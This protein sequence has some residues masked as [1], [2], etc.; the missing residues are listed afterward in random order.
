MSLPQPRIRPRS[1][2]SFRL[3]PVK[4]ISLCCGMLFITLPFGYAF[5][6]EFPIS[7][8]PLFFTA[9]LLGWLPLAILVRG[10][11]NN[12]PLRDADAWLFMYSLAG[13]P[14]VLASS[15]PQVGGIY[16]IVQLF[17]NSIL[18][19]SLPKYYGFLGARPHRIVVNSLSL[20]LLIA[21]LVSLRIALLKGIGF[22]SSSRLDG[23]DSAWVHANTIGNFA[24]L[25]IASAVLASWQPKWFRW[26]A[27][28]L[29]AHIALLSQSRGSIVS[30]AVVLLVALYLTRDRLRVWHLLPLS[31]VGLAIVT[32]FAANFEVSAAPIDAMLQR[33]ES[34]KTDITVG[35]LEE[36]ATLLQRVKE[37]PAFG[38]GFR[39]DG[40]AGGSGPMNVLS[41]TGIIG[42]GVYIFFLYS[43]LRGSI[44]AL[45]RPETRE[46][47]LCMLALVSYVTI[48]GVFE[49]SHL[50][51]VGDSGATCSLILMGLYRLQIAS[52][53]ALSGEVET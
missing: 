17:R 43:G 38:L 28:A 18:F 34:K 39:S 1:L 9:L 48:R 50:M 8:P 27:S 5:G 4:L 51:L 13:L 42:L 26:A 40:V 47:V 2:M 6:L 23:M 15:A 29:G 12:V 35:R 31:V 44:G 10:Y 49:R 16:A 32:A 3:S 11:A 19:Y 53:A 30:L 41:E 37:S 46:L 24:C 21:N 45:Q 25:A 14:S 36:D 33:F 20:G 7:G 22:L 52:I